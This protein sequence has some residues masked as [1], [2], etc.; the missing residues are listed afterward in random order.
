[1]AFETGPIHGGLIPRNECLHC[2]G[3][4]AI[5]DQPGMPRCDHCGGTGIEP[6]SPVSDKQSSRQ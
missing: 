1:M 5:I 2:G 3:S 6:V 4:G